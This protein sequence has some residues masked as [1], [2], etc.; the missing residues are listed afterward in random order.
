VLELITHQ[1]YISCL[2]DS[3]WL[4]ITCL[5][6]LISWD[7][8]SS[9]EKPRW[10]GIRESHFNKLGLRHG[11]EQGI[12]VRL[13]PC[14]M[15][16]ILLAFLLLF[17]AFCWGNHT[18]RSLVSG[19]NYWASAECRNTNFVSVVGFMLSM[20]CSST[21]RIVFCYSQDVDRFG[22]EHYYFSTTD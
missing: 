6:D 18:T 9:P 21:Q 7:K 14:V 4:C 8:S 5:D 16:F 11:L 17:F 22:W 15:L 1:T 10:F 3:G 19:A 20:H 12:L 13:R 2:E